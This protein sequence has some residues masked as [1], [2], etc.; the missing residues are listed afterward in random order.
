[1]WLAC[2]EPPPEGTLLADLDGVRILETSEA[3]AAVWP[4]GRWETAAAL[5]DLPGVGFDDGY[6]WSG[7]EGVRL[8]PLPWPQIQ[9]NRAEVRAMAP[10]GVLWGSA[11]WKGDEAL[12][13]VVW[14]A[15]SGHGIGDHEEAV[16]A[17]AD[18]GFF[19]LTY[20][21]RGMNNSRLWEAE[22]LTLERHAADL[23]DWLPV[24][25]SHPSADVTRLSLLGHGYGGRIA[26]LR[27]EGA[28]TISGP[29]EDRLAHPD[30]DAR[31]A[32]WAGDTTHGLTPERITQIAQ[33]LAP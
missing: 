16:Q 3:Y 24:L 15:R 31:D 9:V 2:A 19:V 10:H 17:L 5:E 33:A 26:Q 4:G 18:Q 20:D 7:D 8:D 29:G 27:A 30:H 12:P 1:M 32:W 6:L 28:Y 21:R 11:V 13:V 22:E 25:E 14:L 23:D